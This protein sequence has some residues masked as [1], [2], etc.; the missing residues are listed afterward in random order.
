MNGGSRSAASA[1]GTKIWRGG[2]RDVT[3]WPA[4]LHPIPTAIPIRTQ[5]ELTNLRIYGFT[6]WRIGNNAMHF[7]IRK[8]VNS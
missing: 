3:A 4:S 7:E 8:F 5:I 6:N 1:A 2:P